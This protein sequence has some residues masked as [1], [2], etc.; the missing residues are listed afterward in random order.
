VFH[1]QVLVNNWNYDRLSLQLNLWHGT[2]WLSNSGLLN[3]KSV[4]RQQSIDEIEALAS[5][6]EYRHSAGCVFGFGVYSPFLVKRDYGSTGPITSH[7][8]SDLA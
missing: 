6:L 2:N 5:D 4:T 7:D 1:D 3:L 8:A